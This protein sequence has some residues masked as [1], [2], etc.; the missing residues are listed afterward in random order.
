MDEQ[1]TPRPTEREIT[2]ALIRNTACY[3]RSLK[4]TLSGLYQLAPL[5]SVL[6][7]D[8]YSVHKFSID[9]LGYLESQ[10]AALNACRT[11]SE[12]RA[13]NIQVSETNAEQPEVTG[14]VH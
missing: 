12:P 8:I 7:D 10:T 14:L 11:A 1:A 13:P 4:L 5:G 6:S 3:L 2:D 9:V